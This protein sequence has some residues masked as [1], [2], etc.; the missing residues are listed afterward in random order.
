MR[1]I[2]N[3]ICQS[4]KIGSGI[5]NTQ[6]LLVLVGQS[7]YNF[8]KRFKLVNKWDNRFQSHRPLIYRMVDK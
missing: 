8:I 3:T 7:D 4:F 5:L 1:V 2:Y 6:P